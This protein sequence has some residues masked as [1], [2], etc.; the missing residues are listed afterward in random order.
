M[1]LTVTPPKKPFFLIGKDKL[2]LFI[3]VTIHF[4]FAG[5]RTRVPPP[6][7]FQLLLFTT[8]FSE[9]MKKFIFDSSLR[10]WSKAT[11][12]LLF[13]YAAETSVMKG[14]LFKNTLK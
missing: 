4:Y 8:E 3:G 13:A 9:L 2:I 5:K 1:I 10:P 14:I 11:A 12:A 7:Y 6:Q